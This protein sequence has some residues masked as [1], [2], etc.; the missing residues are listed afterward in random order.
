MVRKSPDEPRAPTHRPLLPNLGDEN[1]E[2][3]HD[4]D[5]DVAEDLNWRGERRHGRAIASVLEKLEQLV[6]RVLIER[7]DHRLCDVAEEVIDA[8][9]GTGKRIHPIVQ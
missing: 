5:E 3:K 2:S 4:L 8:E 7:R 6:K 1:R 9:A